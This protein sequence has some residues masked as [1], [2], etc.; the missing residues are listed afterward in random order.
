MAPRSYTLGKRAD[1]SE[2]TRLRIL[3]AT[4]E[5]YRERGIPATTLK[6]IAERADVSRGSILHHF[7]SADGLLGA[8]LD[9]VLESL[10]LPD[11]ERLEAIDDRDARI[12]A[13]VHEMVEFQE[14]T[15]HWWP[16]FEAEMQRPEL[17]QREA[18][19]WAWLARLQAVALG[20]ELR[21]DP[22]AN[23]TLVSVIHPATV[24]TFLW[25]FEG[26]GL[27]RGDARPL[28]EDLAVD[29]V[30]RIADRGTKGGGSQ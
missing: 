21:D 8:V 6:A 15:A 23:A 13:F 19:Y 20:P 24:G 4:V 30:R 17:R 26:A 28:L 22:A 29:A 3:D 2:A 7:G 11:P 25:A 18:T 9:R 10:E 14:R 1:T 12:R 16:I 27:P 5:I